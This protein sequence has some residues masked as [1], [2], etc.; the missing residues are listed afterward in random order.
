MQAISV[1]GGHPSGGQRPGE[2]CCC[3]S[4]PPCQFCGDRFILASSSS[5]I[6][7]GLGS[8]S[9]P[10]AA[11][12][13]SLMASPVVAPVA[14]LVIAPVSSLVDSPVTSPRDPPVASVAGTSTLLH[15]PSLWS[16]VS[17]TGDRL[18]SLANKVIGARVT[19]EDDFRQGQETGSGKRRLTYRFL[20][21]G[22][23]TKEEWP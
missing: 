11:L 2:T 1:G 5:R 9:P 14:S 22:Q 6:P 15:L 16:V 23:F 4:I 17:T 3:C 10:A 20:A 12:T 19:G 8:M 7:V 21:G 13:A 18:C